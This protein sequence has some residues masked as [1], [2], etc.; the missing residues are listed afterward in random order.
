MLRKDHGGLCR[1]PTKE[2]S[3][4]KKVRGEVDQIKFIDLRF[5]RWY[6]AG[7]SEIC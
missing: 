2:K 7:L 3:R 5:E 1:A 4:S 6:V